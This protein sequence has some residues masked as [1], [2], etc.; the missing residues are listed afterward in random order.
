[1]AEYH[2]VGKYVLLRELP[3]TPLGRNFRA[4]EMGPTGLSRIVH[5]TRLI[6]EVAPETK[7]QTMLSGKY[8]GAGKFLHEGIS[9]GYEVNN[10][11]GIFISQENVQG[12]SIKAIIKRCVKNNLPFSLDYAIYTASKM[13][14]TLE[15]AHNQMAGTDPLI[16]GGITPYNVYITFDGD[17]KIQDWSVVA[18][19]DYMATA[20]NIFLQRYQLYLAPEQVDGRPVTP[21]V[22]IFQVGL[23]F[24]EMI[25][26]NPLFTI[27]RQENVQQM[28]EDLY[29]HQRIFDGKTPPPEML[30][31][32]S[33]A[34]S[35]NPATRYPSIRAMREELDTLLYSGVY[36]ATA[37]KTSFFINSIYKEEIK[38]LKANLESELN[39]NYADYLLATA[40]PPP[41]PQGAP[42]QAAELTA[43]EI[44]A[45]IFP[46]TGQIQVEDEGIGTEVGVDFISYTRKKQSRLIPALLGSAGVIILTLLIIIITGRGEPEVKMIDTPEALARK[47]ELEQKRVEVQQKEQ[48]LNKTA[49]ELRLAQERLSQLETDKTAREQE[50]TKLLDEGNRIRIAAEEQKKR[51]DTER[52]KKSSDD[53]TEKDRLARLAAEM[54]RGSSQPAGNPPTSTTATTTVNPTTSNPGSRPATTPA[55]TSSQLATNRTLD[56]ANVPY[57]RGDDPDL[58][59]KVVDQ[60]RPIYPKKLAR[61]GIT[62]KATVLLLLYID[63]DGRV[64]K[65]DVLSGETLFVAEAKKVAE[66]YRFTPPVM[67]DGRK[68]RVTKVYPFGF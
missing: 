25:T 62:K 35:M 23:I 24:Y 5:L 2:Q 66:N 11:G 36:L 28:I 13:C 41:A 38:N 18:C 39:M 57:V 68:V 33:K 42:G 34:L 44:S 61:A 16:H 65:V 7:F 64:E 8:F 54:D 26:G 50:R 12:F 43:E 22:D 20:R 52:A 48:Q 60:P 49:E 17:V 32:I 15:Y 46:D 58:V 10:I 30:S 1:M 6:N 51:E 29:T 4:A 3:E 14:N 19:V 9:K 53:Q 59:M 21:A 56:Q 55:T 31:I 37:T 45:Q 47:T 27:N 63:T 67:K 40:T